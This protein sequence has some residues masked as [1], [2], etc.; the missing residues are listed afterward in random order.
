MSGCGSSNST[1]LRV[2]TNLDAQN[3]NQQQRQKR[4]GENRMG[5][6]I[7]T[8]RP[9]S[10]ASN[11]DFSNFSQQ[12]PSLD[13]S[14]L[15]IEGTAG[16]SV[17]ARRAVNAPSS[18]SSNSS[19]RY[20]EAHPFS[21]LNITHTDFFGTIIRYGDDDI[22]RALVDISKYRSSPSKSLCTCP[23]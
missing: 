16:S 8:D 7:R 18:H 15:S 4:I 3:P 2:L 17:A 11:Q 14:L 12:Q 22:R 13:S 9:L 19:T 6:T 5:V 1:P 23:R 10:E 21:V 20:S